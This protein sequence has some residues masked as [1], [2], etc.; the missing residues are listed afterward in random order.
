MLE[1]EKLFQK[2]TYDRLDAEFNTQHG[3]VI[4]GRILIR[5]DSSIMVSPEM[6]EEF[7]R[8]Y[9][10]EVL[11]QVGS[12]S[13]HFC[14]NGQHLVKKMLEVPYLK[15]LDFGQPECMDISYI[16]DICREGKVAITNIR[17]SRESLI[18]GDA[19]REFPTGVLFVYH[20]SDF[21]DAKNVVQSYKKS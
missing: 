12:G 1:V 17:P 6:Y 7:I 19:I 10:L 5:D 18:S 16:Y 4:P 2:F 20:T 9:D 8:P 14:G 11:K 15:G 21:E 3:Y 13:I